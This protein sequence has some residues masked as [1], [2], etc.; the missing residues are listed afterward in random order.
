[1]KIKLLVK[2]VR[3]KL[4]QSLANANPCFLVE[5]QFNQH[6]VLREIYSRSHNN[7]GL[8]ILRQYITAT[9]LRTLLLDLMTTLLG[10]YIHFTSGEIE[11]PIG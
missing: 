2:I 9:V 7:C 1:M 6:S 8:F 11:V 10:K 4:A 3:I 5:N